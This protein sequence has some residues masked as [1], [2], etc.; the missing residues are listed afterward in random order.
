MKCVKVNEL[1]LIVRFWSIVIL[2]VSCLHLAVL[3]V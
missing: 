1:V 2:L 3:P